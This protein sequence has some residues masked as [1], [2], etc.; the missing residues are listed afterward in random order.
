MNGCADAILMASGFSRR[1]GARDKLL[2][3]FG[4]RALASYTLEL[5]C[6]MPEFSNV[7]FVVANDEV[8]RLADDLPVTVLRNGNPARGQCESIRLGVASASAQHYCFFPC[9]QPLLDEGAVRALI[10]RAAPGLIVEPVFDGEP[11]SPSVFSANFRGELLAIPN[12]ES[13]AYVKERNPGRVVRVRVEDWRLL[14][15]VDTS[16][17]LEA[18]KAGTFYRKKKGT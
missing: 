1:F 8:A 14:A 17:E 13:G 6:G 4:G 10:S 7:I 9:D 12:G 18:L 16:E 3:Q 5:A 15:D 11:C 2:S